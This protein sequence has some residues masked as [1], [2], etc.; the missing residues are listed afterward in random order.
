MDRL[1][2]KSAEVEPALSAYLHQKAKV[3]GIPLSGTFE[4]TSRCNFNCKMCYIHTSQCNSKRIE[5]PAEWWIEMG[6]QAVKE[7]MLFLLI[8]GGEPLLRED[9]PYIY[10]ELNKLGL[11][12]SIN[13]NGY[14]LQGELLEL[15]K[16][17]P[18]NR[19]NVSL[20]GTNDDTYENLTGVRGF[21]TV[22]KNIQA[23]REAGIDVRLN[24]S[25]TGENAADIE[26]IFNLARDLNVHVKTTSYMFPSLRNT[27]EYGKND[28][29]LSAEEAAACR[30]K[31]S[32]LRYDDEELFV[33]LKNMHNGL[34]SFE[35]SCPEEGE[36]GKVR[37][38]AGS[39]SFWLDKDGMM[40]MCGI[41]GGGFDAK[42]LGF[43]EAWR[44]VKEFTQGIRLPAKCEH[45]KHRA[46]CHVCAAACYTETGSFSQVPEYICRF[47]E[48]TS[49][50]TKIEMERLEQNL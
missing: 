46:F 30:V 43:S 36:F 38:R 27:G 19:F 16:R 4:I 31:W 20:Y 41:I 10:T 42:K 39:V 49:R 35:E 50:L 33:R 45:C 26:N 25:I 7:G 21:S 34:S 11:I 22:I 2:T 15:F 24:C 44:R 14:L 3:E 1:G 5:L 6:R 32:K 47:C 18:P 13:T 9:F 17:I 37:C 28:S 48:E 23:V 29:R 12:I 8:T 40:A